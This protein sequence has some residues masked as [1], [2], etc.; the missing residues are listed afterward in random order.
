M[1]PFFFLLMILAGCSMGKGYIFE[2][3]TAKKCVSASVENGQMSVSVPG[4]VEIKINGNGTYRSSL[5][6]CGQAPDVQPIG[7][8]T[9]N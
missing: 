3:V 7:T 1:I 9:S 8:V 5:A 2:P 6:E 4:L